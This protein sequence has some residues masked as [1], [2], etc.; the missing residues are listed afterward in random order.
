MCGN[1][2]SGIMESASIP[3][4]AVNIGR[5]QAG[6][7]RAVT[8]V[9]VVPERGAIADAIRLAASAEFRAGVSGAVNPYGDGNSAK[10]IV[11]ALCAAPD[12][13]TLL[14]KPAWM[15][16]EEQPTIVK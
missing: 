4:P 13:Q 7:E 2:S 9:D 16:P 6:R 3:I 11:E 5:R 12:A 14:N 1:S 15:P 8:V 10:R